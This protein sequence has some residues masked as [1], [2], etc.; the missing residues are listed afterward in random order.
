M[1][2]SNLS[3]QTPASFSRWQMPIRPETYH[4]R[5]SHLTAE[6]KELMELYVTAPPGFMTG[7]RARNVL[8]QLSRFEVPFFDVSHASSSSGNHS[9]AV[10]RSRSALAR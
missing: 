3:H 9:A 10:A 6:E 1:Q 8:H 5:S 4:D 7:G 2:N